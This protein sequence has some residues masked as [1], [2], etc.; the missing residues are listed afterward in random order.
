MAVGGCS[1]CTGGW[2]IRSYT[3]SANACHLGGIL[4]LTML[5]GIRDVYL[6]DV[7]GVHLR[8]ECSPSSGSG[9]LWARSRMTRTAPSENRV[10]V[11]PTWPGC[12]RM[13]F[14]RGWV[15]WR[16]ACP[17]GGCGSAAVDALWLAHAL[18]TPLPA[19]RA[20]KCMSCQPSVCSSAP[21]SVPSAPKPAF[22]ATRHDAGFAT[23]CL[24]QRR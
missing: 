17:G 20:C 1:A 5:G 6:G 10:S 14:A 19:I 22:R 7:R 16:L 2:S 8:L 3:V 23:E 18:V 24:S 12:A 21:R 13:C 9:R 11:R 4:G 15:G